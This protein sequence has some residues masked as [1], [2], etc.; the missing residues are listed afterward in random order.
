MVGLLLFMG[1]VTA[2]L[3]TYFQKSWIMHYVLI[4]IWLLFLA[5]TALENL[6]FSRNESLH[7]ATFYLFWFVVHIF[8]N[9]SQ[10]KFEGFPQHL[11]IVHVAQEVIK[12]EF[13]VINLSFTGKLINWNLVRCCEW[14]QRTWV[15]D[16]KW[17]GKEL[18]GGAFYWLVHTFMLCRTLF[19]R[20]LS[21]S[22]AHCL[23]T[24]CS[25]SCCVAHCVFAHSPHSVALDIL[26][27]FSGVKKK[28][29]RKWKKRSIY[30]LTYV[31]DFDTYL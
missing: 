4:L 16:A 7:I 14:S 3:G 26:P 20:S 15:C 17:W 9:I 30:L 22:V 31:I 6:C 28:F 19:I 12:N 1:D 23:F 5:A 13:V 18:F 27:K 29:W 8:R 25:L 10:Y 24:L 2:Y 11:R 21:C